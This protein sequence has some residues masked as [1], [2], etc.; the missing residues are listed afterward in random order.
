[1]NAYMNFYKNFEDQG[2]NKEQSLLMYKI[3]SKDALSFQGNEAQTRQEKDP[4][5]IFNKFS[6]LERSNSIFNPS[7]PQVLGMRRNI[8]D[9][10]INNYLE[11][12]VS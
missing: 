5:T 8:S 6:E 10:S 9:N 7:N 4:F 3:P 12:A 11:Q 1:M 2:L